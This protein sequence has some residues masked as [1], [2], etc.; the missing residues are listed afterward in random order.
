MGRIKK[1]PLPRIIVIDSSHIADF[2]SHPF[3]SLLIASQPLSCLPHN[4]KGKPIDNR[5]IAN[6]PRHPFSDPVI[7]NLHLP[8]LPSHHLRGKPIDKGLIA[9]RHHPPP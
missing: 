9:D 7:G 2:P 5:Y 8:R 6:Y 3:R 4:L 1:W